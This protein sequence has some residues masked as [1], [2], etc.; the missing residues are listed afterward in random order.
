[1]SNPAAVMDPAPSY[2]HILLFLYWSQEIKFSRRLRVGRSFRGETVLTGRSA[3][4]WCRLEA[5]NNTL[6]RARASMFSEPSRMSSVSADVDNC[7][8]E[9]VFIS[10]TVTL[11]HFTSA[12]YLQ[13]PS[14]ITPIHHPTPGARSMSLLSLE[15]IIV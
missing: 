8:F 5:A 7:V 14:P 12:V 4:S 2:A 10:K 6:G 1:M 15:N 11:I 3:R 9:N 13:Y